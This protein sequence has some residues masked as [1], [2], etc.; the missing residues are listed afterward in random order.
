MRLRL[1][2]LVIFAAALLLTVKVGTIWT[3][4]GRLFAG[5]SVAES[6]A[7][8]AS[9][10]PLASAE[11]KTDSQA[12]E[13][14][15]SGDQEFDPMLLSR[16]EIEL[17]RGLSVRRVA[18]DA[19]ER[20]LDLRAQILAAGERRIDDKII[21]LKE[22]QKTVETALTRYDEE[23][24]SRI[25]SL[26]KIYENMKPKN[27]ARIFRDL[28]MDILLDVIERMREAKA[29]PILALLHPDRAKQLTIELAER[30]RV[31]AG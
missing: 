20:E 26:V 27:A 16:A 29:A 15:V 9:E 23:Q 24:E 10:Q 17:L 6:R 12:G 28:E 14:G 30:R 1:L 13:V 22:I 8:T 7:E 31:P 21:E 11:A 25:K 2:P 4:G 18:L 5:L 3:E 19:R